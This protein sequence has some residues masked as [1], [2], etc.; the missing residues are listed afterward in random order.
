MTADAFHFMC[1]VCH[2]GRLQTRK[3]TFTSA[4]Q[5]RWLAVPNVSALVCDVC[6][7]MIIDQE[8]IRLLSGL[9]KTE[10]PVRYNVPPK[11]PFP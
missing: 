9:L 4:F 3:I 7:E 8:M 10:R 5:G 11:R 6:G 1:P 2:L